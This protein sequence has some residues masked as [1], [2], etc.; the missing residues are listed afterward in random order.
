M[1]RT[2]FL[3]RSQGKAFL[4]GKQVGLFSMLCFVRCV[5]LSFFLHS[6]YMV[7]SNIFRGTLCHGA[8]F[9]D[10]LRKSETDLKERLF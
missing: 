1:S 8:V 5:L 7:V 9:G 6:F 3:T 4:G 2:G 10:P